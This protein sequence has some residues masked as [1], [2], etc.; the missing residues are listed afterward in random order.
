MATYLLPNP[1]PGTK[2]GPDAL[3]KPHVFVSGHGVSHGCILENERLVTGWLRVGYGFGGSKT[4]A[5]TRG[6][7][8]NGFFLKKSRE[9]KR[10]E[11][12]GV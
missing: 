5:V 6:Y 9:I 7:G 2:F 8:C 11:R 4:L 10:E 12:R 1:L 3:G